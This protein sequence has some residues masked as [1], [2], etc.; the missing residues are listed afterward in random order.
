MSPTEVP[1][2]RKIVARAKAVGKRIVLPESNDPRVIRAAR[3]ITDLGYAKVVLLGEADTLRAAAKELGV[4]L[5]DVEIVNHL[6][7][8]HRAAYIDRL[9]QRRKHKGMT[10][11]DADALLRKSVYYAGMMVGGGDVD[12]MLAGSICPTRDTVRSALYGV[13]CAEGNKTVSSCS[14]MN[15]IVPSVGVQGSLM[16]ADTGV[17]PE[18]TSEQLA[19]I[20]IAAADATRN[21]LE[22]EPCVAMLSFSSK[23]S[24]SS[25]AVQHVVE[26]TETVRQRRPELMID[27]ELQVDAA[28][29]P[30]VAERKA[31][32]SPVAGKANTL[33]FPNLSCGNIG[34]KLV[35]R[36]GNATALGPL[37]TG[38]ARPVNDL[39]RGCHMEDIVLV[40]AITAVQASE[41]NG[42]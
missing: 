26:A 28:L 18:P 8:D 24:A 13:G 23:G 36:L 39:S 9:Q 3:E 35:E 1:A 6:T 10:A 41:A 42:A 19:D 16:F 20:A 38:L 30:E 22:V 29:I 2:I 33:V 21:L 15:T 5:D 25:P 31:K 4:S 40:T 27:G 34:Y 17:L 32:D 7:D 14:I 11:D 37:L 12:G